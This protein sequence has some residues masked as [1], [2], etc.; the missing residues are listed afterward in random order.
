MDIENSFIYWSIRLIMIQIF[1]IEFIV[2]QRKT[3]KYIVNYHDSVYNGH[4]L[5]RLTNFITHL[6][7]NSNIN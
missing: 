1:I 6:E 2:L 7:S 4:M 5:A 3:L